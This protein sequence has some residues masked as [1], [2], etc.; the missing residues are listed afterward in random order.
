KDW[1]R[2]DLMAVIAVGDVDPATIEK[3]IKARFG[4]LKGPAQ[5][6]ARIAA[7]MPE[8]TGTRISLEAD[9]ELGGPSVQVL[10]VFPHRPEATMTDYRRI[11][12]EQIYGQVINERLASLGR[13]QEAPFSTAGVGMGGF[14]RE[15]DAFTRGAQVKGDRAED[16]LRAL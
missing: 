4:D 1:Y 12:A 15:V 3:E 2:P 7:G 9:K 16:A 10:N 5:P 11:I 13:R 8:T 6:R 14:V